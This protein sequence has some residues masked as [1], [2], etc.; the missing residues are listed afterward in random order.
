MRRDKDHRGFTMTGRR[1]APKLQPI[2]PR[3]A[4]IKDHAARIV[5]P[6]KNARLIALEH[7]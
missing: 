1:P 6:T 7:C 5:D 4:H 3:H 2:H